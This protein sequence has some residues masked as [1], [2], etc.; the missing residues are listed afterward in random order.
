[1]LHA[2]ATR[3]LGIGGEGVTGRQML[4]FRVERH[5]APVRLE[6]DPA[7]VSAGF[8][9][10]ELRGEI[11]LTCAELDARLGGVEVAAARVFYMQ[12]A[13]A[14]GDQ[15]EVRFRGRRG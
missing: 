8:Q 10:A 12:V 9:R 3:R 11:D 2:H 14:A 7:A 1:M 13:D 4:A 6:G 15:R 5:G